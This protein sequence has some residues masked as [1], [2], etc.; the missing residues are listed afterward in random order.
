MPAALSV[1]LPKE[2]TMTGP[3][4]Y[5]LAEELLADRGVL[6]DV[7]VG[8]AQAH[9]TLALAAATAMA[10][11][12]GSRAE[13]GGRSHA[14]GSELV[15]GSVTPTR[16]VSSRSR[17][18]CSHEGLITMTG[19]SAALGFPV[20]RPRYPATKDEVGRFIRTRPSGA[21]RRKVGRRN[22]SWLLNAVCAL[23]RATIRL[24]GP[25]G[26][27]AAGGQGFRVLRAGQPLVHGHW[28]EPSC[29][30]PVLARCR[31]RPLGTRVCH[32]SRHTA[33]ASREGARLAVPDPAC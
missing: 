7:L 19:N 23:S 30:H 32:W 2:R 13:A 17:S 18:S 22:G 5:R 4:H 26:E 20:A 15:Q 24:L 9:A 1:P 6:D 11:N 14:E 8:V 25:V 10:G 16:L 31:A 21:L 27:V 12:F 28:F 33:H 29:A 3:D